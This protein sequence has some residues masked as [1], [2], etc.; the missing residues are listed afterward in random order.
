MKYKA[1]NPSITTG[2]LVFVNTVSFKY[3]PPK[4][5]LDPMN[6]EANNKNSCLYV[7]NNILVRLETNN[8]INTTG[9]TNEVDID[10]KIDI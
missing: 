8:P 2:R 7:W 9:P 4:I 3:I 10:T 5:I 1:P 6:I